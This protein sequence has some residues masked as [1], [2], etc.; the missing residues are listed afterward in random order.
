MELHLGI[1]RGLT[2][3][4][5]RVTMPDEIVDSR[6]ARLFG[7]NHET[8]PVDLDL[9]TED[10]GRPIVA[11]LRNLLLFE[12]SRALSSI[13][14]AHHSVSELVVECGSYLEDLS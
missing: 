13:A 1:R 2:S 7:L 6:L 5:D 9:A 3:D 11:V 12:T 14:R 4:V 8:I 10:T